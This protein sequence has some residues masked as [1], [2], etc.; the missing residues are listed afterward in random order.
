MSINTTSTTTT[1]TVQNSVDTIVSELSVLNRHVKL[2]Q[3]QLTTETI[4]TKQTQ[5]TKN[6]KRAIYEYKHWILS[7]I[8]TEAD[9]IERHKINNSWYYCL[10]FGS[11]SFH[12]PEQKLTPSRVVYHE[13]E[14]TDHSTTI[15]HYSDARI[16]Q[17]I[18][19]L[20]NILGRSINEF[21]PQT[22]VCSPTGELYSTTWTTNGHV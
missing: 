13:T 14:L 12:I 3:S 19:T 16:H 21:L 8:E 10:Y 2:L 4:E 18:K 15:T 1:R 9:T 7:T 20:N 22:T 11:N 5:I 6:R 17:S